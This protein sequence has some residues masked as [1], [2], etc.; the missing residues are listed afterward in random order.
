[1][2]DDSER[3]SI[4]L[5]PGTD[6]LSHPTIR[7]INSLVEDSFTSAAGTSSKG[8]RLSGWEI[9][10]MQQILPGKCQKDAGEG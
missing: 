7:R 9:G 6:I 2:H 5:G 8:G 3:R 4:P 10:E 1:M